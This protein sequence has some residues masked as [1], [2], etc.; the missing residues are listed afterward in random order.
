M[1]PVIVIRIVLLLAVQLFLSGGLA[2]FG[3]V[4]RMHEEKAFPNE[5]RGGWVPRLL[6]RGRLHVGLALAGMMLILLPV[7]V[8]YAVPVLSRLLFHGEG[9][10]WLNRFVPFFVVVVLVLVVS[11]MGVG[12][13]SMNPRRFAYLFSY[14]FFPLYLIFRPLSSF[15]LRIVSLAFPHLPDTLASPF[16]LFPGEGEGGEGFIEENGS[17]LM[18]SIVEFGVKKVREVMVPRI[19]VL[20]LDLHTSLDEVRQRVSVAGHSRVPVYDGSIDRI[21]GILYVKDLLSVSSDGRK[22]S[23]L[24]GLVREAYFVPEGK[25][26]D[27]LL[28]EF[29]QTKKHMAVVVDEYGGTSGIVTLEDI[30]E[31]IVGEIRDEYDQEAPLIRSTRKNEYIVAGR[32]DLDDLNAALKLSIPAEGVDTL[33]GFLYNLIGRVPN[34][35]EEVQYGDIDF[36]ISKLEGQRIVEVLVRLPE[37]RKEGH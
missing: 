16:F 36:A 28:R 37:E 26:I 21:A 1:E 4:S 17:R 7:I 25:K 2:S 32:I 11:V 3:I 15:F 9:G 34:E 8:V 6:H 12:F 27:D 33:G 24:S 13:A 22:M 31:E 35:G 5:Q 29:Q 20:A 14:P 19:D 10:F 18:H 23:D 30:L